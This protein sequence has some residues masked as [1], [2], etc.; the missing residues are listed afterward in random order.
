MCFLFLCSLMVLVF[1]SREYFVGIV[2][3]V[4][5]GIFMYAVMHFMINEG[6]ALESTVK[7]IRT[8]SGTFAAAGV[9][10]SVASE[11]DGGSPKRPRG[12]GA[13]SGMGETSRLLDRQWEGE[14]SSRAAE[15]SLGKM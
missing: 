13:G 8:V 14:S 3:V 2:V 4:I 15:L 5:I 6:S 12:G 7:L 9:G 10:G 11:F 1:D